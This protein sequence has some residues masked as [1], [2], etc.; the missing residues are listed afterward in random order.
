[1]ANAPSDHVVWN[2]MTQAKLDAAYDQ[3]AY[4]AN[5]QQIVSRWGVLSEDI[6][7]RL[8]PPARFQMTARQETVRARAGPLRVAAFAAMI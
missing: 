1:M 7:A 4:A 3:A 6:R 2:G 8:G 5:L